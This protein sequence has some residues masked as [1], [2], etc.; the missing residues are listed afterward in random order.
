MKKEK[1]GALLSNIARVLSANFWAALIG[2]AGSFIFPK[3][4]EIEDYALYQTFTLYVGYIAILHLGFPSGMVINYVGQRYE[5]VDKKQYK[6]EVKLLMFIL[7]LFTLCFLMLF[8]VSRNKMVAY[9]VLAII[10]IG[11]VN[12]YKSLFQAWSEFQKYTRISTFIATAIP[13]IALLYYAITRELPGEVYILVYLFIHWIITLII[14]INTYRFI[15]DVKGSRMFSKMNWKTEQTGIILVL[16]NYVNTLFN[17]TGKQFVQLFF[18]TSDFAFYSFG[19]S[20][21][22]LMTVFITSISQPL[23]PEMAKGE[24]SNEDYNSIKEMLFIFGS[25]SGCAYFVTSI[26]VR[27]FIHKYIGSLEIVGIYFVVF[28]AMA[29]INCLYLNLY[30]IK[31][32]IREYIVTLVGVLVLSIVLD[33]LFIKISGHFSGVAIA[34]TITYYIWLGV[35]L[36]QFRF[37]KL[38]LADLIYLIVY[39][40]GFFA[41]TRNLDD[42]TGIV[43]YFLFICILSLLCYRKTISYFLTKM[44]R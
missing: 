36:K 7:S 17:S 37:L 21:Q 18:S 35:G 31:G 30:K 28:P 27:N 1:K 10:P 2:F 9:I 26:I 24:F 22:T 20:M 3:I 32:M 34:T 23:F 19:M 40:G 38:K 33:A 15:K 42:Y 6:S 43:L 25:F 11:V 44:K 4:L 29:V 14:L 5:D 16:G 41:I 13:I 39:I 12:S 8:L